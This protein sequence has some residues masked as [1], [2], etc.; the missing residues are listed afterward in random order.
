VWAMSGRVRELRLAA[1]EAPEL[2]GISLED[3]Q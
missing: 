1:D 2:A 3:A